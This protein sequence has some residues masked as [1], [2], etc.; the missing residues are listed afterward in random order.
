MSVRARK[1]VSMTQIVTKVAA[2]Q[3][4]LGLGAG[5]KALDETLRCIAVE[6]RLVC[7]VRHGGIY[8]IEYI[9]FLKSGEL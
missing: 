9:R 7:G 1:E 2:V 4:R 5:R 6:A 8:M 3:L